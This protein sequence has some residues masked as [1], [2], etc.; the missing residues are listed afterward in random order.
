MDSSSDRKVKVFISYSH[1]SAEHRKRVLVLSD[2]LC[3]DGIDCNIDQYTE[4]TPPKSWPQWML[5]EI[6]N[7]DY[8]L[9]VWT[10]TYRRRFEGKEVRGRGKGTKW[11]GAI[12]TQ[13]M[14]D[15]EDG[16]VKFIPIVFASKD[17]KHIS[18]VLRG[19]THYNVSDRGDY[20]KLYRHL[21]KMPLTP[22][23]S[24]G[25]MKPMPPMD[26]KSRLEDTFAIG[27]YGD[28]TDVLGGDVAG[29]SSHHKRLADSAAGM[30]EPVDVAAVLQNVVNK[31][32]G[33]TEIAYG[34]YLP[35]LDM[36]QL[37]KRESMRNQTTVEVMKIVG[38]HVC[39]TIN[40]ECG[41]GKTQ[42]AVLLAKKH[43]SLGG[44]LGLRDARGNREA[45]MRLDAA[46]KIWSG[47][48]LRTNRR[49]WY[50]EACK[51]FVAGSML[52][53]DDIPR[54][55]G[56]DELSVRL[57]ILAEACRVNNIK[58]VSTSN[59]ELPTQLIAQFGSD[60]VA[61]IDIPP[62]NDADVKELFEAYDAPAHILTDQFTLFF[63]TL[64]RRN[65]TLLAAMATYLESKKWVYTKEEFDDLVK[66]SYAGKVDEETITKIVK[67]V[68]DLDR[69][70]M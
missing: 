22:K 14:Y 60:V 52:I 59:F 43:R 54:L 8:V 48:A 24:L 15:N 19:T 25:S 49:D 21:C 23:P 57:A 66:G 70:E 33:G 32:G 51:H 68:D 65:A 35:M 62:F 46:C 58:L 4:H 56:S 7:A 38:K 44:W 11:E 40:G 39:T 34:E 53:I 27:A 9:T 3:S 64:A 28:K 47:R 50:G 17:V 30:G 20:K 13:Q 10:E 36:P 67:T 6:E 16:E 29:S 41:C 55:D 5:L 26:V 1:D 31:Y 2:R 45:G 61:N 18:V 12:I 63:S 37:V 69:R 42:L